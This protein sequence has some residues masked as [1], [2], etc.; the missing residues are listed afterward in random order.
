MFYLTSFCILSETEDSAFFATLS[1]NLIF[2]TGYQ[3][4][5]FDEL[6]I[7]NGEYY[8]ATTGIYTAPAP[9]IYQIFWYIRATPKANSL[10]YIDD[11]LYAN[12][13][14]DINEGIQGD[15]S[16]V[17]VTLQAGQTVDVRT[18]S[19]PCTVNGNSNRSWFGGQL[20]F[21]EAL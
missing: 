3:I 8:N 6:K 15:G 16:T 5:L 1:G 14:E 13:T 9:G 11:V 7:N 2:E 17:M 10:L 12:P 21:P 19:E 20:L 4:I 18:G